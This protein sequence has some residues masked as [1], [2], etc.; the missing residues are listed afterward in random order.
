[1]KPAM[2]AVLL[3]LL[4]LGS[5]T[6]AAALEPLAVDDAFTAV[7]PL[8]PQESR[9]LL[10][11][12]QFYFPTR[13]PFPQWLRDKTGMHQWPGLDAPYVKGMDFD[14]RGIPNIP[15]YDQATCW[16]AI[17]PHIC[18]FDCGHCVGPDDIRH[19]NHLVQTFDDGPTA[20]TPTLLNYLRHAGN[21]KASFFVLGIQTLV[22][23]EI[24][25]E[26]R[27]DGHF[28]ASHTYGHKHLPSLSNEQIVGQLQWSIWAMNATA[29]VIPKYFR[30]P[31][32]GV[33]NRVRE[34]ARRLG[35]TVI[36]W[37]LDTNDWRLNDRSRTEGEVLDQIRA[38]KTSHITGIMLEHDNTQ[39]T[40]GAGIQISNII[41]GDSFVAAGCGKDPNAAWY[42]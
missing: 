14:F 34:I 15:Q 7:F 40:V 6:A 12:R 1:M 19:C 8:P 33:D 11:K 4:A 10:G 5:S 25:R 21:R 17:A 3:C 26:M 37:D 24:F 27:R 22:Y 28:L 2:R 18:S 41:G 31:F 29:G 36:V 39:H 42:Q 30:P 20:D 13:E 9:A 38:W 23:P 32:G 35:L 16:K